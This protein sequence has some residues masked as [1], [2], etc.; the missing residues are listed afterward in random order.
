MPEYFNKVTNVNLIVLLHAI[1]SLIGFLFVLLYRTEET[2]IKTALLLSW[3]P[4][5]LNYLFILTTN[6]FNLPFYY[7]IDL[8]NELPTGATL[9]IALSKSG[10]KH[11][12]SL[13]CSIIVGFSLWL[14]YCFMGGTVLVSQVVALVCLVFLGIS[15]REVNINYALVFVGFGLAQ[16]PV[17]ILFTEQHLEGDLVN[18]FF[19]S[20]LLLKLPL[21]SACYSLMGHK[22]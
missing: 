10:I 11:R 20:M 3:G 2:K 4:G 19:N 22:N 18:I 9:Y 13:I 14:L 7:V 8:L 1:V 12:Q 17:H 5:A 15:H 6:L 21:I 16:F